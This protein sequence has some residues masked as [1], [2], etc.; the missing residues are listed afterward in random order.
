[1][2]DKPRVPLP[3]KSEVAGFAREIQVNHCRQPSCANFGVP[4]RTEPGRTGPSADRDLNYKVHSTNKGQTPSIRCKACGDNPPMKSNAS[5][6]A[7][8]RWLARAGGVLRPDEETGCR[9]PDCENHDRSIAL[10][11]RLYR[12][13]GLVGGA[14]NQLNFKS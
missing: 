11:P 14:Q 1:M 10:H 3:A 8:V 7:E 2:A 12:K 9:N 6:A 13:C 5:I 4:A